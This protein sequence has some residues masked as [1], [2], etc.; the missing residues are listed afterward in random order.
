MVDG[1]KGSRRGAEG[2]RVGTHPPV[3][4][5]EAVSLPHTGGGLYVPH[6]A[7]VIP[8]AQTTAQHTAHTHST[9]HT[10]HSTQHTAHSTQHFRGRGGLFTS[11]PGECSS[12]MIECWTEG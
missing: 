6:V 9:Q 2:E 8:S 4:F 10:A 11:L 12:C 3:G 5:G 7:G 1:E